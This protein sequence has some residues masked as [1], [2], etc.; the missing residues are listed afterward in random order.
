MLETLL[1]RAPSISLIEGALR[2]FLAGVIGFAIGLIYSFVTEKLS[3]S[4]TLRNAICL[5]SVII[6]GVMIAISSNI[7]L[8]LGL[9]GSLSIIRFRTVIK[10]P[11]EM[12][13]LFWAIGIGVCCGAGEYQIAAGL[14]AVVT[15]FILV[16]STLFEKPSVSVGGFRRDRFLLTLNHSGAQ[17]SLLD[18]LDESVSGY[19]LISEYLQPS[20]NEVRTT[21]EIIPHDDDG[22][23]LKLKQNL[24]DIPEIQNL[25]LSKVTG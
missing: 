21:Y 8:S 17:E 11:M 18:V 4:S 22:T 25:N 6:A 15:L 19:N 14:F 24:S 20:N 16:Y 2:L 3:Y 7:A 10:D 1:D 13:Y 9:V 12:V 23:L 5:I